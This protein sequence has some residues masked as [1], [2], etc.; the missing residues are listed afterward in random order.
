M[1]STGNKN[2]QNK[3]KKKCFL[4]LLNYFITPENTEVFFVWMP[5]IMK[6]NF[7]KL[8]KATEHD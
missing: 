6:P 3:G 8:C 7:T 2:K 1:L 5:R 4:Q